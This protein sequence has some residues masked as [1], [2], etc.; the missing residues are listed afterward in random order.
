MK[1]SKALL[2]SLGIGLSLFL[3]LGNALAGSDSPYDSATGISGS[4]HRAA[5]EANKPF[6]YQNLQ[7]PGERARYGSGSGF[8]T[9]RDSNLGWG[10]QYIPTPTPKIDKEYDK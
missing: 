8:D 4:S 3:S 10:T 7:G 6:D 5:E 2:I 1:K 9:P